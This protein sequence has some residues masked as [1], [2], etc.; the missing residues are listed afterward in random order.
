MRDLG[1]LFDWRKFFLY[2]QL[3]KF[4]IGWWFSFFVTCFLILSRAHQHLSLSPLYLGSYIHIIGDNNILLKLMIIKTLLANMFIV[5]EKL[6][7]KKKNGISSHQIKSHMQSI[8]H[9]FWRKKNKSV[10]SK[11]N[12]PILDTN[13][14]GIFMQCFKLLV[15]KY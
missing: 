2:V 6:K 15:R 1:Y 7:K 8:K 13:R 3:V 4:V 10:V 12:F 14:A 9:K 11:I 5:I